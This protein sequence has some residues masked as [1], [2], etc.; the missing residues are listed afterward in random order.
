MLSQLI[1]DSK[2]F[3]AQNAQ[4]QHCFICML[5]LLIVYS[6]SYHF[7]HRWRGMGLTCRSF[8]QKL[9]PKVWFWFAKLILK[10]SGSF[11]REGLPPL[12]CR[13]LW[14]EASWVLEAQR[15]LRDLCQTLPLWRPAYTGVDLVAG[16]DV[17][18]DVEGDHQRDDWKDH[19][20]IFQ[21]APRLHPSNACWPNWHWDRLKVQSIIIMIFAIQYHHHQ[22]HL[23]RWGTTNCSWRLQLPRRIKW[24]SSF[25][26]KSWNS[27]VLWWQYFF[28]NT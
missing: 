25:I 12:L 28:L 24:M 19:R 17:V 16:F 11:F 6:R 8:T 20:I 4:E 13:W 9:T 15:N 2:S 14:P 18:V 3:P 21:L 23:R 5:L 26:W 22:I 27:T 7:S 10:R 1:F